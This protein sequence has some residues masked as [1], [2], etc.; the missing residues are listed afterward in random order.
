LVIFENE[1]TVVDRHAFDGCSDVVFVCAPGSSAAY[2]AAA[3]GF[4][5]IN[6]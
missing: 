4:T 6:P 5:V 1:N 3:C 2:C